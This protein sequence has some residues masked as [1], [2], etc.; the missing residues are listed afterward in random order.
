MASDGEHRYALPPCHR[1]GEYRTEQYLG[2]G[3]F[4]ITYFA[5]DEN[6]GLRGVNRV[7]QTRRSSDPCFGQTSTGDIHD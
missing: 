5:V 6:L 4:G 3:G 7:K 2:V 1:L